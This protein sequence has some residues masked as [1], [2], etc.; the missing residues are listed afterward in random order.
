MTSTQ[1]EKVFE[2]YC[3]EAGIELQRIPESG[4]PTPDYILIA[5]GVEIV[6]EV[7]EFQPNAEERESDRLLK[8]RGFGGVLGIE[9]GARVRKKI[10]DSAGQIRSR[11]RG[12][13]PAMLVLFDRG[14]GFGHI[15][16]YHVKTAMYGLEQVHFAVPHDS[17]GEPYATGMSHGPA[18]KMT[19]SDNTSISVIG[20]LWMSD[21]NSIH[22]HVY[23]NVFAA[24]PLRLDTLVGYPVRQYVPTEPEVGSTRE[25]REVRP[26]NTMEPTR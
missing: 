10:N 6:V 20:A 1:S 8:E 23:H 2:R 16:P 17:A 7:K 24:V 18:Q 4:S 15:D 19:A 13:H 3:K 21:A 14:R 5:N 22:L 9:P 26:N 25:W 11:T 12:I